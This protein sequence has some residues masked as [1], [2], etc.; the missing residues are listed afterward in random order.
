METPKCSIKSHLNRIEQIMNQT[1]DS[2]YC[3]VV[4][5]NRNP[6]K[7]TIQNDIVRLQINSPFFSTPVKT[8]S[9]MTSTPITTKSLS[10]V[11]KQKKVNRVLF[12]GATPSDLK[13]SSFDDSNSKNNVS[14]SDFPRK[15][16]ENVY[17]RLLLKSLNPNTSASEGDRSWLTL[18]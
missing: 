15:K 5:V 11:K 12:N 18:G 7:S 4:S 6:K 3:E 1:P 2:E 9:L 14:N 8:V 17:S 16:K 13:G 10:T